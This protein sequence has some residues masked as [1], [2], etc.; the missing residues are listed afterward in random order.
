MLII[1]LII[2]IAQV[3][4]MSKMIDVFGVKL[5][6]ADY[7]SITVLSMLLIPAVMWLEY[8]IRSYKEEQR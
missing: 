1:Y 7:L 4:Y 8:K 5:E 6:F 3:I 2:V